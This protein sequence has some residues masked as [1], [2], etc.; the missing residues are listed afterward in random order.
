MINSHISRALAEAHIAD[1]HRETRIN[2]R[3]PAVTYDGNRHERRAIPSTG[4]EP[5]VAR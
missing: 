5:E 2:R 3:L 4:L 1:L